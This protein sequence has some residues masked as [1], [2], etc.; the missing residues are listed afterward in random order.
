MNLA[1]APIAH[2]GF[3]AAHFFNVSDLDKAKDFCV[4]I[5]GGKQE[6]TGGLAAPQPE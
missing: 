6:T 2:E 3:F 4:R 5:L 1:D